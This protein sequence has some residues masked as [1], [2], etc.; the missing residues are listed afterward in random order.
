MNTE[1]EIKNRKM[2]DWNYKIEKNG[3][4][5]QKCFLSLPD[6]I[7]P[8]TLE[9]LPVVGIAA[10]AFENQRTLHSIRFPKSI[11]SI[12]NH[13]F[14]NC[15]N[16]S[17]LSLSDQLE[18]IEDGAFKNCES[19]KEIELT[20]NVNC[21]T[22]LKSILSE[23]NQGILCRI[24]YREEMAELLFPRYIHDY[25]EN[26]MARIINQETHGSG[27]HYRETIAKNGIHYQEYDRLF[28]VALAVDTEETL[29]RIVI[30]RLQ[31][32]FELAESAKEKYLL[33]YHKNFMELITWFIRKKKRDTLLWISNYRETQ[34]E[35]LE[36][37]LELLRSQG[38]IE[39]VTEL[40]RVKQE[41]FG[42]QN[43]R[44]EF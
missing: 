44:F 17:V 12:G 8:N 15:R 43:K 5:I 37:L 42:V 11:L 38:E 27:V 25:V 16:L 19:L 6:I 20:I 7:I 9:G 21:F 13:A 28:S 39:L 30:G 3:V 31:Y 1:R 4:M 23:L 34:E 22:C 26:T 29:D 40:L 18:E 41:R 14:Y 32:P 2:K 24:Q 33:Y 35:E 10:Y 36:Q